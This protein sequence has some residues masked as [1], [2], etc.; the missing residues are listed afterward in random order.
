[1]NPLDPLL[2]L[3]EPYRTLAGPTYISAV[4]LGCMRKIMP[5]S[6]VQDE[7]AALD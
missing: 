1:M 5:P 4:M 7:E 2:V 6:Y 3:G